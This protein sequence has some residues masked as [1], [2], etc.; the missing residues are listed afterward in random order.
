[1]PETRQRQASQQA[2]LVFPTESKRM[3]GKNDRVAEL[4]GDA[5]DNKNRGRER[6][7]EREKG[8]GINSY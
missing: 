2:R 1:M 5:E 4:K 7:R 6:E 8:I 3:R